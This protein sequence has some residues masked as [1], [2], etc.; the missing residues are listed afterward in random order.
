MKRIGCTLWILFLMSLSATVAIAA[1]KSGVPGKAGAWTAHLLINGRVHQLSLDTDGAH[2]NVESLTS[3]FPNSFELLGGE[4]QLALEGTSLQRGKPIDHVVEKI[5]YDKYITLRASNGSDTRTVYIRTLNSLLPDMQS[6]GESP[7]AGHYY[8]TTV[9]TK[10]LLKLDGK[11]ELVYYLRPGASPT[12]PVDLTAGDPSTVG[13]MDPAFW[14]FKKHVLRDGKIRYSYHDHNR[15]YNRL[16]MSGFGGGE[17]VILDER[18]RE[19]ARFKLLSPVSPSIDAVE[20]H[21]FILLD[22]S[23]YIVSAYEPRMVY[24]IPTK[25]GPNPQGSKV[26]AARLQEVKQG[27]VIFDWVSTDHAELYSL[28]EAPF[29]DFANVRDQFPDYAHFNSVEIDPADGNLLCSFRNIS[30]IIKIDRK[31]GKIL[32]LLSGAGDQFGLSQEQKTSNQHYARL[33]PN[34]YLTVFDNNVRNKNTRILKMKLDEKGKRVTDYQEFFAGERFSVVCGSADNITG[35][36]FVI[37]WGGSLDGKA[38]LT[39][40][41]FTNNKKLF[42]LSFPKNIHTYRCA[43]YE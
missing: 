3:E 26:V 16:R 18:Y 6:A 42:E 39:E 22:D 36:V 33:T 24:N 28:S 1:G 17:R 27:K 40:I 10:T 15:D 38:V 9:A 4:L 11:G 20:G 37:G 13:A 7:H 43:K 2:V 25:C 5:A 32:W 29:N 14:D 41:D 21:D 30:S 34:G 31:T 35:N 19:I 23:H 12:M 8:I